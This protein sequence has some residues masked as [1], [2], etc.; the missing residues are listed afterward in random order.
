MAQIRDTCEDTFIDKP[1]NEK[2]RKCT[3]RFVSK[4]FCEYCSNTSIHGIGYLGA[5]DTCM[6]EKIWWLIVFTLSVVVCAI[7]INK[8]WTKWQNTPV[9]M[10][11]S[12]T[13]TPI[14]EIP[15]PAV[16]IC[17]VNK[18]QQSLYNYTQAYRNRNNLSEKESKKF[19]DISLV[20]DLVS[21]DIN[22]DCENITNAAAVKSI[23]EVAP[24]LDETILGIRW[25]DKNILF[26]TE[27]FAPQLTED[28]LCFTFNSLIGKD[29]Y[30]EQ[31]ADSMIFEG[32]GKVNE[33][34]T[35][36]D[37]YQ[38]DM[39]MTTYPERTAREGLLSGL[40]IVL[41][42][43]A[44]QKD[45]ACG[46]PTSGY[47]LLLHNPAE[48]PRASQHYIPIPV[49]KRVIIFVTPKLI[50][51]SKNVMYIP[52]ETRNC[53]FSYE[54]TLR[55]YKMYTEDNCEIEC[56][57]NVTQQLCQCLPFYSPRDNKTD[58][59]GIGSTS[60]IEEAQE[61][62]LKYDRMKK[63]GIIV[64]RIQ[65]QPDYQ[66][67]QECDC[68]PSCSSLHYSTESSQ[69]NMHA[70][71]TWELSFNMPS[72]SKGIEITDVYIAFK[73][74]D[75]MALRRSEMYGLTDFLGNCGGLLGLF[76]GFSFLSFL[77]I[78][79]FVTLRIWCRIRNKKNTDE[80]VA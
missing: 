65:N 69:T 66:I 8:T 80:T 30:T 14:W 42:S 64:E 43:F 47:K 48:S 25:Q 19:W 11:F 58:I 38:D 41:A 71:K 56:L 31:L 5:D 36:E 53:Y 6:T 40:S 70:M 75:F 13:Q 54:K 24:K 4:I 21:S 16:T 27:Y 23:V 39:D 59:C 45:Y 18:V 34:W 20:C 10:T 28:G 35:I 51:T 63:K 55:F 17:P 33:G 74:S 79:Y 12:H 73:E 1:I 60:C 61:R 3:K 52:P 26:G 62:I 15:F 67:F 76:M 72:E 9:I 49:D 57:A 68:L 7:L 78:I 22:D 44:N 37:G 46:E 32:H 50:T 29:M 77:E 2:K